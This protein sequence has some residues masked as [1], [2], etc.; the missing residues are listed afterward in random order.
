MGE[1]GF[2]ILLTTHSVPKLSLKVPRP[3]TQKR[4]NLFNTQKYKKLFLYFD[5][6]ILKRIAKIRRK[7]KFQLSTIHALLTKK[8]LTG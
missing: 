2:V 6:S 7:Q 8:R 4:P 5:P 1:G 3:R